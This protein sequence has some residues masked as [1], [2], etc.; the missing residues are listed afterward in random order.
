MRRRLPLA[1]ILLAFACTS[2]FAANLTVTDKGILIDAGATG[3]FT[4]NP[5]V[6]VGEGNAEL[7]SVE[8]VKEGEGIRFK[9]ANEA[10]AVVAVKDGT[11][12]VIT[13]ANLPGE[14]KKLK[15]DCLLPFTLA[16]GGKW[17]VDDKALQDFPAEQPATPFLFQGNATLFTFTDVRGKGLAVKLPP[18]SWQQLQ[19]NRQ[20]N[21]KTFQWFFLTP[22]QPNVIAYTVQVSDVDAQGGPVKLADAFGQNARLD[23]PGKVKSEAELKADVAADTAYYGRLKPPARDEYGGLPDSGAKY[24][25]QATGFFHVEQHDGRWTMVDP[26]GNAFFHLGICSALGSVD[27]YTHISGREDLFTWLP[28]Y[29]SAYQPAFRPNDQRDFSFYLANLIRKYGTAYDR[30]AWS[31]RMIERYRKWG[32]NSAGA[33]STPTAAAQAMKFPY[34]LTLPLGTWDGNMR[35]VLLDKVRGVFDPFDP[36]SAAEIERLFAAQL[37]AHADDP[38][39]IGYFLANEQAFEDIP[40]VIPT[41]TGNIPAKNRL[42]EV[43]RGKYLTI[44][45]FNAAWNLHAASFDALRNTGLPVTTKAAAAD[46]QDYLALFLDTYYRIIADTFHKYD[47]HHMLLGN[48]WMPSTANNELLCRIS[49]TYLDVIS[50]NYYTYAID[51]DFLARL[52]EWCGGK[53][54]ILSEFHYS[55]PKDSG[56]P[57]GMNEVASQQERGLAYRQYVEQAAALG[58]VVGIEWFSAVDQ[59]VTGRFFDTEN[60]NIGLVNVADRPYKAMLAEMMKANYNIYRVASREVP[61]FVFND[62]RFMKK[63][64]AARRV[65]TAPRALPG[66]AIDGTANGW[67]GTPPVSIPSDRLVIGS[68]ANGLQG[69][70]RLCYDDTNL[71]LRVDVR[72]TTPM[73]NDYTGNKIWSAD[74]IELFIGAENLDKPGPLQFGDRQVLLSAGKV[75]DA[76]QWY[77]ANAPAQGDCRLLVL[78]A[79]DGNGYILQAALPFTALGFTPHPGQELL[80]DLAIDDSADGKQRLRQLMWNGIARNSSDRGSWGRLRLQ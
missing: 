68:M 15:I 26:A 72:D 37:P 14:V 74:A 16:Q 29:N 19:D 47:H 75:K 44:N 18:Y 6:L 64:G 33:F 63:V 41:L 43:L 17:S 31:A 69:T 77:Y 11:C 56:L 65:C 1:L 67:P 55:A 32:F 28:D 59:A 51:K 20:W 27:D 35:T 38:L 9:Y 60:G 50:V 76:Y 34:V 80:F 54:F 23:F 66:I 7:K 71:Y 42:V 46:M 73:R 36:R 13:L 39:L 70:F 79:A 52:Y 5:P 78:P 61:P 57:G 4:L 58:S 3:M 45:A 40:R 24:G 8:A 22:L 12:I 30:E 10:Q 2:V 21:W 25:L 49:R 53:P 48:R 62:P